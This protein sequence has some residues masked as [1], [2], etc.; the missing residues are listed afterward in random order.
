MESYNKNKDQAKQILYKDSTDEFHSFHPDY[1]ESD[2]LPKLCI[3]VLDEN[4]KVI[5]DSNLSKEFRKLVKKL[6]EKK[7]FETSIFFYFLVD[8]HYV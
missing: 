8:L 5:S 6:K 4:E 3:G 1:V 7:M 2:I